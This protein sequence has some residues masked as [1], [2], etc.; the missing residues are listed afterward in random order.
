MAE[1]T[2]WFDKIGVKDKKKKMPKKWKGHHILHN[3]MILCIG[4]TGTENELL[5]RLPFKMFWLISQNY[6]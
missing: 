6:L 5:N 4:G 1:I 2:N 3:S